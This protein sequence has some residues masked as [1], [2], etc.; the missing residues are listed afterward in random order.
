VNF[1]PG[2]DCIEINNKQFCICLLCGTLGPISAD[3]PEKCHLFALIAASQ[4]EEALPCGQPDPEYDKS[5]SLA[6]AS[7]GAPAIISDRAFRGVVISDWTRVLKASARVGAYI[8]CIVTA[9]T[10]GEL[11]D[12]LT[13][14]VWR[15]EKQISLLSQLLLQRNASELYTYF[16]T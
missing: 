7:A 16:I 3:M 12:G 6:C 15:C 9:R 13:F 1:Q 2:S 10:R 11:N 4:V 8:N 5:T 14:E